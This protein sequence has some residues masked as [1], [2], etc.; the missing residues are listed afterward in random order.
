M[1]QLSCDID[2]SRISL[3]TKPGIMG[4]WPAFH[5]GS[6]REPP[7]HRTKVPA[8]R[9]ERDDEVG[10]VPLRRLRLAPLPEMDAAESNSGEDSRPAPAVSDSEDEASPAGGDEDA[11]A[12]IESSEPETDDEV[13]LATLAARASNGK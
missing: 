7:C 5:N 12:D 1:Q 13:D 6:R 10:L 3:I 4:V 9:R 8:V 2:T 11:A